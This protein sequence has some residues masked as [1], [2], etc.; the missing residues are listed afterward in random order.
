MG[1]EIFISYWK[2]LQKWNIKDK[3]GPSHF[4]SAYRINFWLLEVVKLKMHQFPGLGQLAHFQFDHSPKLK[5]VPKSRFEMRRSNFFLDLIFWSVLNSKWKFPI[6]DFSHKSWSGALVPSLVLDE[7]FTGYFEYRADRPRNPC[8]HKNS[9]P[10]PKNHYTLPLA[11]P[12]LLIIRSEC[13]LEVFYGSKG[14]PEG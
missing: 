13:Y 10:S 8:G 1:R 14:D 11:Y 4:K 2:I 6:I 9:S 12:R 3:Y 5:I 7:N